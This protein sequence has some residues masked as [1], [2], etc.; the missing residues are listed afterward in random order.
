MNWK[1]KLLALA[2]W[3]TAITALGGAI[4]TLAHEKVENQAFTIKLA[5]DIKRATWGKMIL[6]DARIHKEEKIFEVW[7]TNKERNTAALGLT[8]AESEQTKE[9]MDTAIEWT[10]INRGV[11]I[12]K[13]SW[14]RTDRQ[15]KL[16]I[17]GQTACDARHLLENHPAPNCSGA[18]RWTPLPKK[19]NRFGT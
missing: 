12:F 6:L 8:D 5:E 4:Y 13:W 3:G 14:V 2:I 18:E 1:G 9:L 7:Y 16:F 19:N 15:G 17:Y 10:M 11:E